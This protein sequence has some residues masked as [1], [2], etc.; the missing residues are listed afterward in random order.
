MRGAVGTGSRKLE[1]IGGGRRDRA[2]VGGVEVVVGP[3]EAPPFPADLEVH[4]EDTYLV[5]SAEPVVPERAE[6]P[7]RV[8]TALWEEEPRALG[9]VVARGRN[10]LLAVVH[11]LARDP[12][13]EERD[14][15]TALGA[16]L[17][18]ADQRGAHSLSLPLLGSVHGPI[19]RE[20][21]LELI[22]VA[23]ASAALASL[24]RIWVRVPPAW[25]RTAEQLMGSW[26]DAP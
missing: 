13:T 16:A 5:L 25:V 9:A 22:R 20:R 10:Q 8:M 14:V 17:A 7:I 12:S 4:E 23:I 2:M 24:Q 1:L 11:D 15:A 26:S 3:S 18:C 19:A 6:H 21:S